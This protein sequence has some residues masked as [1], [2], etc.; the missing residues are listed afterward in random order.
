MPS[1]AA[2]Q[3]LLDKQEIEEVV[4]ARYGRALDWLDMDQLKTCFHEDGWVDYGF[5]EGNAHGWCEA[6]MPIESSAIHRFHYVFNIRVEVNGDNA[7][8]E[9]NS[10]AGSR[11]PEDDGSLT[12]GF[13][14]SRYLDKLERRDGVWKISERRTLLEFAQ[15][16]PAG[17]APGG[18]LE[19][20]QLVS[21]LGPDHPLYR[22]MG[23]RRA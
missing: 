9:S 4:G 18:G 10:L 8:A 20:L 1:D 16:A 7:D 14:G 3:E 15:F 12:Q 11:R 22:P 21:G 5:Y 2:L 19:G 23:A 6:V 13:Y 17:G